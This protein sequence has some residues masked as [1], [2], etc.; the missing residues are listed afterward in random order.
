MQ[1]KLIVRCVLTVFLWQVA[2]TT[3]MLGQAQS[4]AAP[5]LQP[6][7]LPH[8][9]WHFLIYVNVLDRK[10]AEMTT[11]GKNGNWLR[12]DLQTKLQFSDTD[13]AP[14]RISSGR[15]SSELASLNQ[16][17]KAILASGPSASTATQMK[18]LIAQRERYIDNEI[19][20]LAQS[21]SPQKQASLEAF[22]MQF[23]APKPLSYRPTSSSSQPAGT[24]G[25]Q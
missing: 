24:V 25:A 5:K 22:M 21:L 15:L 6:L 1:K 18:A 14:I 13:F 19:V 23:F 9:Y 2:L 11:Q 7:S 16:Q 8:L 10:A 3:A 4:G 12:N 20:Y 17:A